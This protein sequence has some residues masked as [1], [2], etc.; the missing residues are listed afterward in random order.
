MTTPPLPQGCVCVRAQDIPGANA[1]TFFGNSMPV[2]TDTVVRYLGQPIALLAGPDI[3]AL[4]HLVAQTSIDYRE[5]PACLS[6]QEAESQAIWG[7]LVQR[8]GNPE[9]AFTDASQTLSGEYHSISQEQ[10]S[11]QTHVTLAQCTRRS[12]LIHSSTQY[13]YHVRDTVAEVLGLAKSRVR[14]VVPDVGGGL[15]GKLVVPSLIAAQAALLSLHSGKPVRF[16]YHSRRDM[17]Y[18]S[19]R[20]PAHVRHSSA[21]NGNGN[22]VGLKVEVLL[23]AGA[24]GLLTPMIAERSLLTACGCYKC[25]HVHL[26]GRIVNTNRVPSGVYR[27]DGALASF[28]AVELHANK[29][30]RLAE[31]NPYIWRKRNLMANDSVH[32]VLDRVVTESDFQRKHAAYEAMQKRRPSFLAS[33]TPRRGTGVAVCSYGVGLVGS[34]EAT[35]PH[36]VKVRLERDRS[37]RI[38]S[39]AVDMG[40]GTSR[41]LASIA[42]E[43]LGIDRKRIKVEPVD[44]SI[45]PDSGPTMGSR[46]V[47]I[48]GKLVEQCCRSVQ[49]KRLRDILPI[50]ARRTYRL[51]KNVRWDAAGMKGDAYPTES[52]SGTAAEVEIDPVTLEIACRGVWTVLEAGRIID[53]DIARIQ[54]EGG[55]LQGIGCVTSGIANVLGNCGE[56]NVYDCV[57]TQVSFLDQED[58]HGAMGAKGLGELSIVGVVPAYVAAVSQ[59]TGLNFDGIPLTSPAIQGYL[60]SQSDS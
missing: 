30:A 18:A 53:P 27:G 16:A 29:L 23:D 9:Q 21:V 36:S 49:R 58:T 59:A 48:V 14:V 56:P 24:Y 40:Q 52:Y 7:E 60:E 22:L 11:L 57:P 34:R 39:S 5:A 31:V 25:E 55:V 19:R 41:L 32:A 47:A 51:P 4:L 1:L 35:R 2:L 45:V 15:G 3:A 42:A 44:T 26:R 28:L 13:P 8:R 50:E 20:P 10:L 17:V 6:P 38:L 54:V 12:A 43:V 33:D 37:V 46:S